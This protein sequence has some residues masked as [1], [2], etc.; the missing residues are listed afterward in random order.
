MV[1][2]QHYRTQ[3]NRLKI[4]RTTDRLIDYYNPYMPRLGLII[5][6]GM[7][8]ALCGVGRASLSEE[9]L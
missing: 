6:R 3:V 7:L 5:T 8:R 9:K 4:H 2:T 1:E